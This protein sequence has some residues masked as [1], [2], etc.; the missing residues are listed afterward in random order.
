MEHTASRRVPLVAIAGAAA[1]AAAAIVPATAAH[2]AT[3]QPAATAA[4]G[5][6]GWLRLGHLS[7]DTKT[8]DVRVAALDG[9]GGTLYELEGVGYGDVSPYTGFPAGSY[10]VSMVPAGSSATTPPV[11]SGTVDVTAGGA[12]TVAAYGPNDDLQVQA[13]Q[14]DLAM[15][16]AGNARIRLIQASTI[17]P[18]VDVATSTGMSIAQD[19]RAGSATSYAEVPAGDWTLELTGE[20]VE[21]TAD[22]SVAVGSVS[23]LFVL[24]NADGGLTIL[25]VVDSAAV[26]D[27][28]VGGVATGG[29]G[30]AD[31]ELAADLFA[32]VS[33]AGR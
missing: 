22:V 4:T 31:E 6:D 14:D 3:E 33:T 16:S 20:D 26:G 7:P 21:S 5:Q 28:P 19:A 2:A 32:Y 15:P 1:L 9:A 25:P 30:L 24:D 13:F 10:T 18:T 23:S 29:G 17:T 27:V 12:T 8:V 11:I